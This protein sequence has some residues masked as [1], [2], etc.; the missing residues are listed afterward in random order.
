MG[1]KFTDN[2]VTA[3]DLQIGDYFYLKPIGGGT[4]TV[5]RINSISRRKFG[6]F[7]EDSKTE[8]YVRYCEDRLEPIPLREEYIPDTI[9]TDEEL[10]LMSCCILKAPLCA[11][12]VRLKYIHEL[13]HIINIRNPHN[14]FHLHISKLDGYGKE[15]SNK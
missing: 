12:G 8:R 14:K 7:E 5:I 2:K 9:Y 10:K 11:T 3:R 15:E 6:Y 1:K 13:Q 4:C